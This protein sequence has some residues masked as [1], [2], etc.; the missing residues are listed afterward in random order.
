MVDAGNDGMY[1]RPWF[2][3]DG[4]LMHECNDVSSR[5]IDVESLMVDT[6]DCLLPNSW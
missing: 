2:I 6:I 1:F 3:I 4:Y 5:F